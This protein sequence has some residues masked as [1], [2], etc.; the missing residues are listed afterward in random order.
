ME[1]GPLKDSDDASLWS[2]SSSQDSSIRGPEENLLPWPP[3]F[4][5][6]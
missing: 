2:D 3:Y 5:D 6:C 4:R 1:T